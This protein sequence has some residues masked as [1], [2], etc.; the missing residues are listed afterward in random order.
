M[1]DV[2]QIGEDPQIRIGKHQLILSRSAAVNMSE[3]LRSETIERI[4][5]FKQSWRLDQWSLEGA[6]DDLAAREQKSEVRRRLL[7]RHGKQ[8]WHILRSEA[9]N[10]GS[11][12]RQFPG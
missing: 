8:Q 6:H 7:L 12:L 2:V 1:I 4:A 5:D 11:L 9:L 3:V 10:L